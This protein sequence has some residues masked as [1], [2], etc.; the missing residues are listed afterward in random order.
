MHNT[1]M[2]GRTDTNPI[3]CPEQVLAD[4]EMFATL[5]VH[6]YKQLVNMALMCIF[7]K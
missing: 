3:V 7:L 4:N 5:Y 6:I 2:D 1:H